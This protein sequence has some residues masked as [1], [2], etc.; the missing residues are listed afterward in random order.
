MPSRSP[1]EE[2]GEAPPPL[3]CRRAASEKEEAQRHAVVGVVAGPLFALEL[4]KDYIQ[5][6][7]AGNEIAN[8]LD[9]QQ[10]LE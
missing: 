4:V 10:S 2:I 3:P 9:V 1:V 6:Y 8:L 5:V 7:F